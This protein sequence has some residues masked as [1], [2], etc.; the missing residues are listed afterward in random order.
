M[1]PSQP[2]ETV[3]VSETFPGC[4]NT[5]VE[6]CETYTPLSITSVVDQPWVD[7][8]GF[9]TYRPPYLE[10]WLRTLPAW[11]V[12]SVW[13]S[14][15]SQAFG[16]AENLYVFALWSIA[17]S[18]VIQVYRFRYLDPLELLAFLPRLVYGQV[19]S[20]TV[21]VLTT[22]YTHLYRFIP[23]GQDLFVDALTGIYLVCYLQLPYFFQYWGC[24]LLA[25]RA[26][27]PILVL[28]GRYENLIDQI[29]PLPLVQWVRAT[30]GLNSFLF[31]GPD[32]SAEQQYC[33]SVSGALALLNRRSYEEH[34]GKLER[35]LQTNARWVPT[36]GAGSSGARL[37]LRKFL[38]NVKSFVLDALTWSFK[39][40]LFITCSLLAQLCGAF[41]EH[42]MLVSWGAIALSLISFV[43]SS[44][45]GSSS[46][47][48][49]IVLHIVLLGVLGALMYS[50]I[51]HVERRQGHEKT[52][53]QHMNSIC[54][55]VESIITA[56]DKLTMLRR[57]SQFY[58]SLSEADKRVFKQAIWKFSDLF[59]SGFY[60]SLD[61]TTTFVPTAGPEP[62]KTVQEDPFSF[63]HETVKD[64]AL[65]KNSEIYSRLKKFALFL[66]IS[67]FFA[68]MGVVPS[69]TLFESYLSKESDTIFKSLKFDDF[70]LDLGKSLS[71]FLK[72]GYRLFMGEDLV[73][74][75]ENE[76]PIVAFFK[77]YERIMTK[78]EIFKTNETDLNA[79]VGEID[80]L[81][82]KGRTLAAGSLTGRVNIAMRELNEKARALKVLL[83]TGGNKKKPFPFLLYGGSSIGKSYL[84]DHFFQC[85]LKFTQDAGFNSSLGNWDPA[86]HKYTRTFKDKFWSGY[87]FQWAVLLDDVAFERGKII[88]NNPD[89]SISEL[90]ATLNNV[91]FNTPQAEIDKKGTTPLMARCLAATTNVKHLNAHYYYETPSAALRRM[92][93]VMNVRVRKDKC[94]PGTEMLDDS[95]IQDDAWEFRLQQPLVDP[96]NPLAVIY[97]DYHEKPWI[98]LKE[99]EEVFR[100]L[101]I[102]HEQGQEQL[103]QAFNRGGIFCVCGHSKAACG[104]KCMKP[105]SGGI[106]SSNFLWDL[107]FETRER[108]A[109]WLE[110]FT[111]FP[112]LISLAYFFRHLFVLPDHIEIALT[113]RRT[114]SDKKFKKF[115]LVAGLLATTLWIMKWQMKPTGAKG[116]TENVWKKETRDWACQTGPVTSVTLKD[117]QNAIQKNIFHMDITQGT[118][119]SYVRLFGIRGRTYVTVAHIF[120][121]FNDDEVMLITV[122]DPFVGHMRETHT[123]SCHK[124]DILFHDSKDI[125]FLS[126]RELREVKDVTKFLP[127]TTLGNCKGSYFSQ[128]NQWVDAQRVSPV[129]VNYHRN[130]KS[131]YVGS[132]NSSS[133][134]PGTCGS[135]LLVE[136]PKFRAILGFSC[137][138]DENY[139]RGFVGFVGLTMEDI[140]FY[141]D[142]DFSFGELPI[143]LE[144]LHE[145]SSL[146]NPKCCS[147]TQSSVVPLG[148]HPVRSSPTS[149]VSATPFRKEYTEMY[150]ETFNEPVKQFGSPMMKGQLCED[151]EYRDPLINGVLKRQIPFCIHDEEVLHTCATALIDD[152]AAVIDLSQ[153]KPVD[154]DVALNGLPGVKFVDPLDK[155]TSGG[156]GLSGPKIKYLEQR[157]DGRYEPNAEVSERIAR[158]TTCYDN[159]VR[160]NPIFKA[161]LKDEAVSQT[162]IDDFKTRVFTACSL[163]FSIVI[164][165]MFVTLCAQ[166]MEHNLETGIMAGF[167]CYTQWGA[168]VGH[169]NK[170]GTAQTRVSAGDYAGFDTSMHSLRIE[171]GMRV[172]RELCERSGNFTEQQLEWMHGITQDLSHPIVDFNGDI[173]LL[174]GTNCSG[175]P[176]TLILNSIVNLV[177]L[178]YC[179]TQSTGNHPSLFKEDVYA[180][181]MGD[182]NI[183][184]VRNG[185]EFGHTSV[186]RSLAEVGISYTMADKESLSVQH[187]SLADVDFLKRSFT[188][189][190]QY[191]GEWLCP[192]SVDSLHKMLTTFVKSSSVTP[193]EQLGA[194]IDTANREAALHGEVFYVEFHAILANILTQ[195]PELRVW[196][197]KRFDRVW[198]EHLENIVH[199]VPFPEGDFCFD[200]EMDGNFVKTSWADECEL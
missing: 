134:G 24:G 150:L 71:V 161:C 82:S 116:S 192:L 138:M 154:V 4:V 36:A 97:K 88:E 51:V 72:Y 33:V 74:I 122:K 135:P 112:R 178:R 3:K 136:M 19:I 155:T 166:L 58:F 87:N 125:A 86:Q 1:L 139:S 57:A 18:L 172:L 165:Q 123:F 200:F 190:E 188:Q 73:E 38:R 143:D 53:A 158:I 149:R 25:V 148:S 20:V 52:L 142:S 132:I 176:L 117:L 55:L 56:P 8:F 90:I 108:F 94:I 63:V 111:L 160:A 62:A 27:K 9:D 199:K 49:A 46:V 17:L 16:L 109:V 21:M 162:K 91:T 44:L 102:A 121:D 69:G 10:D 110:L 184:A 7:P 85:Y 61:A 130:F 174:Y 99:A 169:L 144:P 75:I 186:Q 113:I 120:D 145:N 124:A 141:L 28:C 189:C 45:L 115:V 179:Y 133:D 193:D 41:W 105:T 60:E 42:S 65:I 156:F 11:L 163:D 29:R 14:F 131:D 198:S 32:T 103:M 68:K 196:V 146:R 95:S 114:V 147:G 35:Y 127:S 183:F 180:A 54:M 195:H 157:A 30:L 92:S 177:D 6:S 64:M 40:I 168:L 83:A 159:K 101:V 59:P 2:N 34:K 76:D 47:F 50:L 185:V 151:G 12:S 170:F 100:S 171:I 191:P 89:N 152:L 31:S 84:V 106:A 98:S 137:C 118:K 140:E 15:Q 67:G 104:G 22:V 173:C 126:F 5:S 13:N 66:F 80:E 194:I 175:H 167:D 187:L 182:D 197:H 119:T 37:R 107:V 81:L 78:L 48:G 26:V 153:V 43:Y 128:S 79:I 129:E 70:V 164:R 93:L 39:I 96:D 181:V 77:T 23:I